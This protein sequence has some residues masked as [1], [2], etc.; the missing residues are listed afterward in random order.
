MCS[1]DYRQDVPTT[2]VVR[3]VVTPAVKRN[4][5]RDKPDIIPK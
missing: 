4:L 5:S 1:K 2:V 3:L